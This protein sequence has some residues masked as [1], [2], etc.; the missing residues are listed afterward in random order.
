MKQISFRTDILP[1]KDGLYRLALRLTMNKEEAEDIVQ[2]TL[3]KVW[4]RRERWQEIENIEGFA[5]TIC[6]NL[7]LDH[8]R[9]MNNQ[10]VSLEDNPMEH[11]DKALSPFGNTMIHDRVAMVREIINHLPEKQRACV[12]LRDIEG[13]AY[14]DI[15]AILNISEEQVKINIFR[16]RQ[17]IRQRFQ[18]IENF[19]LS[20]KKKKD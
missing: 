4:K 10:L 9:R 13:K 16:A 15:A 6:H 12:Q 1:L 2:E 8:L 17:S 5:M 11:A 20:E 7:S 14:K 18:A 3:L 19:K